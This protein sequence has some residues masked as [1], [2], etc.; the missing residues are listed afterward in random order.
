MPVTI[1]SRQTGEAVTLPEDQAQQ[2]IAAG[3]H[4]LEKGTRVNIIG[5]D[6]QSYSVDAN[7]L[8]AELTKYGARLESSEETRH[9]E[10]VAEYGQGIGSE[11]AA[12][13]LGAARGISLGLSDPALIHSGLMKKES[14][15]GYKEALPETSMGAELV[16]VGGSLLIPGMGAARAGKLAQAGRA[17]TAPVRGV[18][19][20]GLAVEKG[21]GAATKKML[22][23][24]ADRFVG[25]A[26]TKATGLGAGSA[27][28]GALYGGGQFIS[29]AS[30]G[31]IDATAE[32]LL[33][34][35]GMGAAIGGGF[36][37]GLGGG[38]ESLAAI[39]RG[40]KR[41][42]KSTA[43]RVV[44]LWEKQTGNKAV[45]GLADAYAKTSG[46]VS[47]AGDEI[48]PF[49]G[50][51][52]AEVRRRSTI[53]DDA[54]STKAAS[55]SAE[56]DALETLES[57]VIDSATGKMKTEFM[58]AA[59][60]EASRD[61]VHAEVLSTLG[62]VATPD[63][64]Q[65]GLLGDLMEMSSNKA[66]PLY[67]K[68]QG[69]LIDARKAVTTAN[70][71]LLKLAAR[72]DTEA[73]GEM[74]TRVDEVKRY[75][76]RKTEHLGNAYK[77]TGDPQIL[78][79]IEQMDGQYQSLR[80]LLEQ[81]SIW[82]KTASAAQ[83]EVN[84]YWVPVMRRVGHKPKYRLDR[85]IGK[86]DFHKARPGKTTMRQTDP[87]EMEKFLQ[88]LGTNKVKLDREWVSQQMTAKENLL[89]A[90]GR[91]YDVDPAKIADARAIRKSMKAQIDD[92]EKS[93]G[94]RN[95]LRSVEA[96]ARGSGLDVGTAAAAGYMLG[97]PVGALIGGAA[98][99]LINP[100]KTI[101]QLAT[102]D[103]VSAG[104]RLKISNAVRG[105][106]SQA[107]KGAAPVKRAGRVGAIVER[108]RQAKRLI[109]PAAVGVLNR[110][111][112]GEKPPNKKDS[113]V[114]AYQKRMAELS[115]L[116][117]NPD[118][119][120]E[121]LHKGTEVAQEVAPKVTDA[122]RNKIVQAANFLLE[123]A[124]KRPGQ[125]G[126]YSG[127]RWRPPE[128]EIDKW[129]RYIQAVDNPA[130]VL[131]DLKN[132]TVNRES[133]EVL[134][135]LYPRLYEQVT[136]E[137]VENLA[138]ISELPYQERIRLDV[139]FPEV[140]IDPTMRPEFVASMQAATI[141]AQP[142]QMQKPQAGRMS[143]LSGAGKPEMM[144]KSQRLAAK[145]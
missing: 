124:P 64:K 24:G 127:D 140:Q 6:N 82:G 92:L 13:A 44:G 51:G 54:I 80:N 33:G 67:G 31:E 115:V 83:K 15:A 138:D 97:G 135:E 105:F 79:A 107:K 65:A 116:V 1:Y 76:G 74:F 69:A 32:N 98:G 143:G 50:K 16:G 141:K 36:G 102:L 139:L 25:R 129:E 137:I 84:Q 123:K 63:G 23:G 96:T 71:D 91:H 7:D 5:E 73:I 75:I 49:F 114:E 60:K 48:A 58:Q 20:L 35:V 39:G 77:R 89:D 111:S 43:A 132:G 30:L 45:P 142:G 72:K 70:D 41:M 144:T 94:M 37:A 119:A 26:M 19:K 2:A 9:R 55:L 117:N 118:A 61:V 104:Y 17:V 22:G 121:R 125:P 68:A 38:F 122:V 145:D 108:R 86:E 40:A 100:A 131:D 46:V 110:V 120:L 88:D 3:T 28:E 59:G 11:L 4:G 21:V 93:I 56:R 134:R 10:V 81:D 130:S 53:T 66:A 133:V 99:A 101:R 27:V 78:K 14:I 128:S 106:T 29:E 126:M 90:I 95:Q 109:A 57:G 47:G 52:G 87:G 113:R 18:A 42:S 85:I 103:R 8:Q 12:G 112:F 34:H 62:A 136:A